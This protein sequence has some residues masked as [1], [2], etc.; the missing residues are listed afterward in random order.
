MKNQEIKVAVDN[1]IFTIL[2]GEVHVL[3]IEMKEKLEGK[4]ALPGGLVDNNETLKDA[5]SR[6]LLVQA[7]FDL[8][9]LEQ[10][11][12]FSDPN[13]DP[14]R[15]VISNAF[16]ALVPASTQ[17][18]ETTD[19]YKSVKWVPMSKL[20]SLAYDHHRMVEY[21]QKHL[22]E[23]ISFTNIVWSLLPEQ[24]TFGQLQ[25]AYETILGRSLDKRNFKRKYLSLGLLQTL[26]ELRK[27]GPHRPAKLYE[28]KTKA[29]EKICLFK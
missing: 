7:N 11:H 6:H 29:P 24:F 22:L 28:F 10:L 8:M 25:S 23:R 16:F 3:L 4:W 9:F 1:V 14:F 5:A 20:P 26:P 18:P 15:R 21:A 17:M 27:S 12:A 19:K 13:R 2:D